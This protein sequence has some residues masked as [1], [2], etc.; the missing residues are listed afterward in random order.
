[1]DCNRLIDPLFTASQNQDRYDTQINVETQRLKDTIDLPRYHLFC[2]VGTLYTCINP[3]DS[4][5]RDRTDRST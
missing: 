5:F 1:M 2:G 4:S 3:S